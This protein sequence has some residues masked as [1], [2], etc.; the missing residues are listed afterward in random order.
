MR[1]YTERE[2]HRYYSMILMSTP[3]LLRCGPTAAPALRP[4]MDFVSLK[5]RNLTTLHNK[6]LLLK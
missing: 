1:S 2:I 4:P 5:R 6:R 3:K